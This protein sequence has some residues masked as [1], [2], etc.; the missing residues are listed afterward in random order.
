M[1][2]IGYRNSQSWHRKKNYKECEEKKKRYRNSRCIYKV[3]ITL[4]GNRYHR[5]CRLYELP[6]NINNGNDDKTVNK[7]TNPISVHMKYKMLVPLCQFNVMHQAHKHTHSAIQFS[8][9][10]TEHS[11]LAHIYWSHFVYFGLIRFLNSVSIVWPSLTVHFGRSFD[12]FHY[13]TYV[14][15]VTLSKK[16]NKQISDHSHPITRVCVVWKRCA[17]QYTSTCIERWMK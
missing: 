15:L 17:F 3:S 4:T 13:C 10:H 7:C 5:K 14:I 1:R 12:R 11:S 16:K 9:D 8:K 6:T 2:S